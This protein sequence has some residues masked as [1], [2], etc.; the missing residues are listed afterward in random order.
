MTGSTKKKE[1]VAVIVG[2]CMGQD[3][4][5]RWSLMLLLNAMGSATNPAQ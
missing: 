4:Q 3:V 1:I 2:W 5:A